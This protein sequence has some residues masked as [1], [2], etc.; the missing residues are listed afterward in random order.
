MY[1]LATGKPPFNSSS[2]KDLIKM[3]IDQPI[4]L[5]P[6]AS[7]TFIDLLGR[8]LEKDPIRRINWD[9]IKDHPFW[10]GMAEKFTKRSM[11]KEPQFETYLQSRGIT[12]DHFKELRPN[13][14][15]KFGVQSARVDIMRLSQNVRKN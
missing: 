5:I 2:F 6:G 11:P 15:R 13:L 10:E 1:E 4:Q 8:L 14:S 12:P 3:I 7:P 9:E